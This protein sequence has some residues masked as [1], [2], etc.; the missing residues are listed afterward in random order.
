MRSLRFA[1]VL[2]ALVTGAASCTS[3]LGDFSSGGGGD[4]G[5][6]DGGTEGGG[7]TDGPQTGDSTNQ[8]DTGGSDAPK[9][10][11]SGDAGGADGG[12]IV[13]CGISLGGQRIVTGGDGGT[14]SADKLY[15]Y[16]ASQSNVLALIR[17]S[18]NPSLAFLFRSDRPGDAPQ[19]LPLQGPGGIPSNLAAVTRSV[20]NTA[21]YVFGND[22]QN[23][24]LLWN[25]PDNTSLNGTPTSAM[26]GFNYQATTIQATTAGLF[27]ASAMN[28]GPTDGGAN[29]GGGV[30]V[31]FPSSPPPQLP[32]VNS[33]DMIS[34]T[35]D[36]GLGDGA[37]LYRLSDDSISLL[38]Y[39]SDR[40]VH[41]AHFPQNKTTPSSDRQYYTGPMQPVSWQ[42]DGTGTVDVAAAVPA[43]EA[44]TQ[45][46]LITGVLPE[47]QLFTF[48]PSTALKPISLGSPIT[49]QPCLTSF[50]GKLLALIPTS[51]GMDLY[52]ID[53]ATHSVVY[54]LTGANTVLNKDTSIVTC[55]LGN[56]TF[57]PG[58]LNFEL[59]WTDNI[60][61]GQQNLNYAPLQC[62]T[63]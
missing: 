25:W 63:Q 53:V 20:D 38:Y 10:I 3:I 22:N 15:V 8:G 52:I 5:G 55:A 43:N 60:G 24:Q 42:A 11:D 50:P 56:A 16:N 29:D 18:N 36:T 30:Y 28:N 49:S 59:I 2:A 4:G 44:G 46:T 26:E 32:N 48:N 23:N 51:A 33:N 37:R 6:S 17:T 62:M 12:T 58:Q 7:T 57:V 45:Y 31:D 9:G 41:Q 61:N 34:T 27:Y 21:T 47:S 19:V 39:A 35:V 1:A 13:S 40:T 54:S 14:I